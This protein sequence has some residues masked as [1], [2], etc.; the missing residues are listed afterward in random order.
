M[1]RSLFEQSIDVQAKLSAVAAMLVP[2]GVLPSPQYR[3]TRTVNLRLGLVSLPITYEVTLTVIAQDRFISEAAPAPGVRIRSQMRCYELGEVTRIFAQ[4][5]VE[6]PKFIVG[7]IAQQF[8][9]LQRRDL[10]A[11]RDRFASPEPNPR[12]APQPS[13]PASARSAVP[14]QRREPSTPTKVAGAPSPSRLGRDG[15]SSTTGS[16][17]AEAV[18]EPPPIPEPPASAAAGSERAAAQPATS[19]RPVVQPDL[20]ATVNSV[21]RHGAPVVAEPQ[22]KGPG[23]TEPAPRKEASPPSRPVD[24]PSF[25]LAPLSSLPQP[26]APAVPVAAPISP[27]DRPQP[28][29]SE[30]ED[31]P[32]PYNFQ[33][34]EIVRSRRLGVR[35]MV[36]EASEIREQVYYTIAVGDEEHILPESD[37]ERPRDVLDRLAAGTYGY[38]SDFDLYARATALQCAFQQRGM[39]CLTNARLDPRPHQVFV[40]HRVLQ[41]LYP[42]MLLADEV[43]LGKTIE[44]GLILKELKARGLADRILI[45]VPASLC[46]QWRGELATKFNETFVIYNSSTIR[47]NLARQPAANPWSRD[48]NIITSLQFA[49]GQISP[50]HQPAGRGSRNLAAEHRWIDEVNWDLVIFDEAHHLRRYLKN[51]STAIGREITQSYRLAQ[52]V[53]ERTRSLLLLTATPLQLTDYDAYSLIELIDPTIFPTYR[54]FRDYV[55]RLGR[56]HWQALAELDRMLHGSERDQQGE[57]PG[58]LAEQFRHALWTCRKLGIYEDFWNSLTAL[59]GGSTAIG[60]DPRYTLEAVRHS[61]TTYFDQSDDRRIIALTD[62]L[63]RQGLATFLSAHRDIICDWIGRQHK[64]SQV[65][66]R[67]RKREV[68]RGEIVDRH[69]HK[70]R[71][72]M[73]EEE[74]RLYNDVSEYIKATN[75]RV[76]GKTMALGFILTTFRKLLVSSRFALAASFERRAARLEAALGTSRFGDGRLSE[77][78]LDE[79]AG[80]LDT[81]EDLE[82]LLG[83]AGTTSREEIQTDIAML[84]DLARRA[85]SATSDSKG[86]A[87]LSS[88]RSILSAEPREKLLIFTQFRQTQSYLK[89]LL[90]AAGYRV[91]L[92]HGEQSGGGYSKRAEFDRFKRDPE[93]QIMISTD[94]G[95]EGLNFQFCRVLFNYDLPWNPMNVE[96]RIGRLDRIGQK[97]TVHIYNFF[98]EDTI[99]G[100]ILYVLQERIRIFEET[101]GTLDPIIGEEIESVIRSIALAD[102]EAEAEK[103]LRD[104]AAVAER[105]I[106][107]A[108]EAEEKLADFIMDARSFRRDTVDR[109][110]GRQPSVTNQQMEGLIRAF[111]ARYQLAG[112]PAMITPVGQHVFT[113]S[114]P[115]AFREA[116]KQHYGIVLH[117][118]YTGTFHPPTA[119]A[120][121]TIDFFAFGHPLFDAIVRFSTD[122][123][124]NGFSVDGTLRVVY[125]DELAGYEGVQFNYVIVSDGVR[126]YRT[127]VPI[128]LSREGVYDEKLS[129]HIFGLF[130]DERA[131]ER[132]QLKFDPS[133]LRGLKNRSRE[134]VNAVA[135]REFDAAEERNL[136]E[137]AEVHTKLRRMFDYRLDHQREELAS[138]EQQL[139]EAMQVRHEM[140]IRLLQGQVNATKRRMKELEEQR[141]IELAKLAGQHELKPGIQLLNVALV[142]VVARSEAPSD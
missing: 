114:V 79:I 134:I 85:R 70:V 35:G 27:V 76:T 118:E 11:L 46:E 122:R 26:A 10:E 89:N 49:R 141:D 65:M 125:D 140:R 94:V 36:L 91:V 30:H 81:A 39:S 112:R 103:R 57:G 13:P 6:A 115:T 86:Q 2:Q 133:T 64:L 75:A 105:R 96:Q 34:S 128:V 19:P 31:A 111:L 78:D 102:T 25:L 138:R 20:S 109:I 117:S 77:E 51:G 69:A 132:A 126:T 136:R 82:A 68:L 142:K 90:E 131:A 5:D 129:R 4:L 24:G 61:Y 60:R 135:A 48:A 62:E 104:L 53:E 16:T 83:L 3:Y 110:L 14:T 59:A 38:A 130:A 124:R 99:D 108:R 101:I 123:A 45:V 55:A 37:L 92:F 137:F 73:T 40:A 41:E 113:I 47:D 8:V 97:R 18:V 7:H 21:S 80:A 139:E 56:Q 88:V 121:E 15:Q 54:S 106:R 23:I 72:V 33:R 116:Y 9:D 120:E 127:M 42:R 58:R 98:L 29:S 22:P 52:A 71:V 74:R 50:T 28:S 100:R 87:L 17:R 43:G 1:A 66:I 12:P 32:W 84:R 93:S 63:E 95:G 44:A 107:E 119:I 67:N